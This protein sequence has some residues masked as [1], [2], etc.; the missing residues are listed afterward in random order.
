MVISW[1]FYMKNTLFVYNLS[2]LK[3][4]RGILVGMIW[5]YGIPI[6]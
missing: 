2:F 5:V 4:S 6:F 3:K 1:L